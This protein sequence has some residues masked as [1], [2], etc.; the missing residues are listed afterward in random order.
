MGHMVVVAS[1]SLNQWA[2]DWV[3]NVERVIKSIQLA[4]EA[5]ARLRVGP[6]LEITG[7]GASIPPRTKPSVLW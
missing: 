6:E 2:L 4:K 1:C 7:Y 5:G 3:G